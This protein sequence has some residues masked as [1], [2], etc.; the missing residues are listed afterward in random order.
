MA[1]SVS[2][3]VTHIP[4]LESH[5][6]TIKAIELLI[7]LVGAAQLGSLFHPGARDSFATV[8]RIMK[9]IEVERH[10]KYVL[11]SIAPSGAQ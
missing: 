6:K 7:I 4:Q 5:P 2:A 1:A 10:V 8:F 9:E 3:S 11:L